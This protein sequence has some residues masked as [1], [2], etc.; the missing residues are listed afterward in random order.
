M[1]D[2]EKSTGSVYDN[3][4]RHKL[5]MLEPGEAMLK[6]IGL[7]GVVGLLL[8]LL[9]Q[10]IILREQEAVCGQRGSSPGN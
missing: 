4:F 9:H 2:F 8:F 6:W 7:L 1:K 3:R 10:N 5:N